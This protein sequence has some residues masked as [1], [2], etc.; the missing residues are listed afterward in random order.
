[1]TAD[2]PCA[3]CGTEL[4][5]NAKFCHEC[6]APTKVAAETPEYK[7]VTVLFA[8]VVQSMNIAAVVSAERLRE[9]MAELVSRGAA[10]VQRYGGTMEKFTGDG[11]MALF[12]APVAL[13]D[14]AIRACLAALDIQTEA[15]R[16][17]AEVQRRDNITLR[18]RVGLN[19]GRVV[20]GEIGSG[21]T[22][23][24]AIGHPVGYAQRMESVAPP[25]GVMLSEATATLVEHAA[26]V[27]DTELVRIKGT[28]Q[29]VPVRQLLA[30]GTPDRLVERTDAS[31]VGRN[32]E[33][34][35]VDAMVDRALGGRG[36]I[37]NV[38]GPPGIGKSRV[39]REVAAL[40]APRGVEV[41]WAFCESH[42]ADIPFQAVAQ[43]LRVATRVTDLDDE[44]AR[45]RLRTQLPDADPVDLLLLDDL[46]GVGQ[47]EVALPRIEPDARR[48]RLTA[49]VNTAS[50]AR[51]TPGLFIIE[52]A[53]WI[54]GVSESMIA[55]F[56]TVIP[57]TPSMVL[58]TSR[59]EYQGALTRMHGSQTVALAPLGDSDAAALLG[60][61]LGT[62]PSVG[63]LTAII[64]DR[65][66]GNPFFAEEMVREL[67]QRG[68]LTGDRGAYVCLTNVAELTVP[69][70]VETAIKA[71][72][73]RLSAPA[74]R[75][76]TAAS[77]I[78]GHFEAELFTA[79]GIDAVLDELLDAELID[80]VRFIAPAEYAFHHP[81]IRTVAYESQLK[82]DR[83]QWH[84]RLAAAIQDRGPG[85]AEAAQI[86]EHLQ[87]AGEL[88]DAYR[89]HMRAGAW[90]TS[91]DGGAAR[92]SWGRA[93]RIADALPD[94][95]PDRLS[96]RI[97]PRTMLCATG[98]R[99]DANIADHFDELA[100]LCALT[101]DKVSLAIGMA[102]LV[103]SHVLHGRA[104]EASQ[105]ASEQM[106]LL[107]SLGD[108][109]PTLGLTFIAFANWFESGDFGEILRWSQTVIDLTEGD[110]TKGAG[111]GLDSPLA[112]ALTWRC[113]AG[114]WL[115]RSGWRRDLQDAAAMA[116]GTNAGTIVGVYAWTYG[117]AI[118]YGV[119]RADDSAVCAIEE[120]VQTAE[121][122]GDDYMLGVAKYAL[123]S[124]LLSRDAGAD[125]DRGLELMAQGRDVF[126]RMRSVFL[127]PLADLWAAKE[128]AKRGKTDTAIPV[129]RDAVNELHQAGRI[130][131]GVWGTGVLVETLLRRGTASD[132][133]E[134]EEQIQWLVNVS[135][136]NGSAALEI[137][138]LR[139]RAL[140]A[141]ASGDDD[142]Y[143]DLA[144]RYHAMATS[145]GFEGHIA[146]AEAMIDGEA[147]QSIGFREEPE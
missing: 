105:L 69:A 65:A 134:A 52:D 94:D 141:Q 4:R 22:G 47:P 14:H 123:G 138:L 62:D 29:P 13:E 57:Q 145:L 91:R 106:A 147:Q 142:A 80:Q 59:P 129:M 89:W 116:R 2:A 38:V 46:L 114:W 104:R 143:R 50:L 41:F 121:E 44:G 23:Y 83:A 97:A 10:V 40:A 82:S 79:L 56:L 84:R 113:V 19:S 118:N 111:F 26:V 96:M 17:A 67:V 48:R 32:W 71:R 51:T 122:E 90:S 20:A 25:G 39:A 136:D 27:K 1:M 93:R 124:A 75:T 146:W 73:D 7:Q 9:I 36:G 45:V 125:G 28:D 63:K 54:D 130:G 61:L 42:T 15:A 68:A 92:I 53:H 18:L 120:A 86:A 64:V 3:T 99:V 126:L 87:A 140:Q 70:T 127:V 135:T 12:G 117:L 112:I 102:G 95:E 21:L 76:L 81:L 78:G 60:E 100:Q 24:A 35:V 119:I 107:E 74:K 88:R 110:P 108:P 101:G 131:Y 16:L 6:G 66:A 30:I 33:M 58:I 128:R 137:T 11:L 132:L 109:T 34:A 115:D 31:L 103:G 144:N 5:E 85:A 98:W 139:L 133:S 55:D 37:V 43:L 72:I 8:D 77:V 49:L